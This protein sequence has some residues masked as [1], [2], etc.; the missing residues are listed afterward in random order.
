MK[1]SRKTKVSQL[2]E[3]PETILTFNM[4]IVFFIQLYQEV[5]YISNANS[6]ISEDD[7]PRKSK[8]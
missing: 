2:Q 3:I 8:F 4:T 6:G 5:Y 7:F 1:D